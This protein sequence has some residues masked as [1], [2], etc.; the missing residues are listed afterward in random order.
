MRFKRRKKPGPGKNVE[1]V[2]RR[3]SSA[4]S[5]NSGPSLGQIHPG[6]TS[7]LIELSI[8]NPQE[9]VVSEETRKFSADDATNFACGCPGTC[10]VG[11]FDLSE[12]VGGMIEA[13]ETSGEALGKC[14]LEGFGGIPTPCGYVM[15]CR[16]EIAY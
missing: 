13:Q 8:T 16:I 7:L 6:V 1:K 3:E 5:G 9:A 11:K 15:K 2:Q 12:K 14:E 10:G 4:R